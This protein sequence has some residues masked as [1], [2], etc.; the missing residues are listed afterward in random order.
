MKPEKPK[1]RPRPV[2]KPVKEKRPSRERA[3]PFKNRKHLLTD[4]IF[5]IGNGKSRETFDLERL[6]GKGTIIGCNALYR[7]FAPDILVAIDA[8]LIKEIN[9]AKYGEEHYILLPANR[10]LTV[11]GALH[12]R[13]DQFNTSGCF[14]MKC[15][16]D[17]MKPSKCYMLGMDAYPGNVYDKTKNYS[18][19]TLQ[20]FSGVINFY[21]KVLRREGSTIFYNVNTHDTWTKEA[22]STG[23]Y[24]FITFE[25]FEEQV[26]K[27]EN[28]AQE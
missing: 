14:A 4:T 6:R 9:E 18:V 27:D 23:K 10:S 17:I 2:R 5:L 13:T 16:M 3:D 22:H 15:I 1:A 11:K 28:M 19:N 26:M 25:E 7:D 21:L 20:N 12:W 8:K 24:R